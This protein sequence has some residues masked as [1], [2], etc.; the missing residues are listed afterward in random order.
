MCSKEP[1]DLHAVSTV[2]L[3]IKDSLTTCDCV[4]ALFTFIK[5]RIDQ[6][7]HSDQDALLSRTSVVGKINFEGVGISEDFGGQTLG[8]L[9]DL[10]PESKH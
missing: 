5:D 1:I 7:A 6:D 10:T 2:H 4:V 9:H 3:I 8:F